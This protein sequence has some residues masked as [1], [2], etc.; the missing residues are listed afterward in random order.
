ML[1]RVGSIVLSCLY[2]TIY[3]LEKH[4]LYALPVFFTVLKERHRQYGSA[5]FSIVK[6]GKA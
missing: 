4:S 3:L 1:G 2:T 5:T 6:T